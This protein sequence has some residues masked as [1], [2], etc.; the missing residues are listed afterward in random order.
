MHPKLHC[1]TRLLILIR[2]YQRG[3]TSA[4]SFEKTLSALAQK[5]SKQSAH[6]DRLRQRARRVKVSWTLY[7]GFAYILAAVVLIFVT[8]TANWGM[9]EYTVMAGGPVLYVDTG[10]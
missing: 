4:E 7:G 10:R 3:S 2:R 6:N 5:I 8:G 1:N 9:V